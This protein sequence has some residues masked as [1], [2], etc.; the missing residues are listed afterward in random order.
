[1]EED[2][3]EP[4]LGQAAPQRHCARGWDLMGIGRFTREL[5]LRGLSRLPPHMVLSAEDVIPPACVVTRGHA[6][7]HAIHRELQACAQRL[8]R[9]AYDLLCERSSL[10]SRRQFE[11]QFDGNSKQCIP[12]S[13]N[14]AFSVMQTAKCHGISVPR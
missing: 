11:S 10:L 12:D 4:S 3:G 9:Q 7:D 13:G 5:G 1:M 6:Q 8:L 14:S 2:D